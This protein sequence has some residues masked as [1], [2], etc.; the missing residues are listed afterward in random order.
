MKKI[1]FLIIFCLTATTWMYSQCTTITGGNYGNLVVA[2]DGSAEQIAIDN[3]P[4]AEYSA[5]EGL[6]PGNTYTVTGTNTTSIYITIAEIDWANPM[7]GGTVLVHGPSS[8]SFTA[9]T[10]DVIIHWHLDALCSTQA[11]DNTLTTI[12]CT[13]ATCSC[14]ATSSPG[15]PTGPT[16]GNMAID[17]PI[18]ATDP[19]NLLI[20]PFSWVDGAGDPATSYTLSL[21]VTPTGDDIGS[22]SGATNGNGINYTWDYN[23]TYYWKVN[24][25]NCFGSDE[26]AVWSF[27]TTSCTATAAPDAV[28]TPTPSDGAIDVPIDATDPANLLITPFSWVDAA[29]GDPA[30]SYTLSLGTTPTGDDIGTIDPATNGN[31]IVYTWAYS[32][33]YYWYVT[34]VNCVG[35]AP[36]AIY[37]FTT[38][39]DPALSIDE[40]DA[41]TFSIYPNPA[42]NEI[43]IKTDISFDSVA[44]Y[45]QLGQRVLQL[46]SDKLIDN[47]INISDLNSGIFFMKIKSNDKEQ[48][49]KFI[50]E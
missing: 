5:I 35:S 37:S 45:N 15:A 44:I 18:D 20:T 16:P 10:T 42:K 13:S 19:A 23:T 34:G 48:T 41:N 2:N 30:T 9:T 39:A 40:F 43:S 28:T 29:T 38:E 33:T 21:G 36:G 24:A 8:V 31:G 47:T 46:N 7:L 1:T 4:N 12:Q 25:I 6:I 49:I 26:S 22:I 27:T 11:S 3:W 50:K 32:T 17:I 14:T